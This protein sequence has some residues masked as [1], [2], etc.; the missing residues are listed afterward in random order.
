M[1]NNLSIV[2]FVVRSFKTNVALP[3][4]RTGRVCS[5]RKYHPVNQKKEE[6]ILLEFT[7]IS[8]C[9]RKIK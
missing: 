3:P 1:R 4:A 2:F 8:V 7:F 5:D 6:Y 9:G